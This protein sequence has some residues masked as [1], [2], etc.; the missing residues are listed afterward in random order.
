MTAANDNA[1]FTVSDIRRA[2]KAV[3]TGGRTV[4][5]VDFPQAGGFRLLIG[6]PFSADLTPRSGANEWDDVLAS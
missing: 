5:A 2:I 4:A 1:R 6:A 3:E